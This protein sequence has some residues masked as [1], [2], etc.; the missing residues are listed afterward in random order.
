MGRLGRAFSSLGL[1]FNIIKGSLRLLGKYPKL[2][3]PLLPVFLMVVLLEIG[4]LFISNTV[5]LFIMIFVVAFEL[6]FSFVI[7]SD[8]IH[9]IH[10][11]ENPSLGQAIA[12]QRTLQL[13]PKVFSLSLIWYTLIVLLVAIELA[14]NTLLDS[15]GDGNGFVSSIFGTVADA[16]RMMGFML[17]PIMIF[18]KSGLRDAFRRLK[19]VLTDSP[20]TA[21]GGLALTKAATI[22]IFLAMQGISMLGIDL[23]PTG[24][25]LMLVIAGAGW[26]FAIYLEQIFV[27]GLF[28][29]TAFPESIV[30]GILLEQHIGRELPEIPDTD[31]QTQPALT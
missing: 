10:E 5:I 6:M 24:F 18:D 22:L 25:L 4:F 7:T 29:Y 21:L 30:V 14:I 2:I 20:V 12:S 3:V 13:I 27:T 26:V 16:L 19:D 8:M 1:A 15:D 31:L 23:G 9:Q 28:L 17:I 11:G